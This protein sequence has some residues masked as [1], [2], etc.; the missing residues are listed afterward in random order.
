MHRTLYRPSPAG[1]TGLISFGGRAV[2]V[3]GVG[4]G[5]GA[6]PVPLRRLDSRGSI[7]VRRLAGGTA[8]QIVDFLGVVRVQVSDLVAEGERVR[9][10]E[11]CYAVHRLACR[12]SSCHVARSVVPLAPTVVPDA[13]TA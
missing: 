1:Y 10:A 5:A 7:V 13:A 4:L 11:H 12:T 9:I 8:A 6:M 3:E 2:V